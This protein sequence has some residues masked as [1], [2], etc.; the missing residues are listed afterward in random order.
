MKGGATEVNETQ[1]W[2]TR[3]KRLRTTGLDDLNIIGLLSFSAFCTKTCKNNRRFGG[4]LYV[5][6][7]NSECPKKTLFRNLLLS[8][9]VYVITYLICASSL[10]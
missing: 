5:R 7:Q 10:N 8:F 4:R 2:A 6:L 9:Q 1:K 3:K